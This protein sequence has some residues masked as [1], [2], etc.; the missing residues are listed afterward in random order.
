MEVHGITH[1]RIFNV[2][3]KLANKHK[4]LP[5]GRFKGVTIH[6]DGVCTKEDFES[7]LDYERG[8]ES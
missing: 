6:L 4:F 3:L 5:I 1:I 2:Q 7:L 8:G